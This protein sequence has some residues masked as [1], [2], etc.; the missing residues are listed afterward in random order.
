MKVIQVRNV[1]QA[2]PEGCYQIQRTGVRAESRNGPVIV[3]PFPLTTHYE[4][5]LERVL[6]WPERDANPFFHFFESLW[7]LAGNN[8]VAFVSQFSENIANYSDDGVVFNGAYGFRWRRHFQR[9]QLTNVVSALKADHTCRR[10]VIG[11]WDPRHDLGLQSKD[12][13]CNTHAYVQVREG[14]LDMMVCNRSND[15]IWGAYGANAVHFSFLL[16]YLAEAIGV[17]VGNYWQTSMNT[18]IYLNQHEALMNTM[19]GHAAQP[20]SGGAACP[21]SREQVSP[22][23]VLMQ[24]DYKWRRELDEFIK[25]GGAG[26]YDEAFFA[27]VAQPLMAAWAEWKA[28][29]T[30][31]QRAMNAYRHATT[32]GASDWALA[33]AEWLVR[34]IDKAKAKQS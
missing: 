32:C 31:E 26:S 15:M 18:H 4:R 16:Q 19:A 1:H 21:Y 24:R 33:C 23:T 30:V 8:D 10:Q 7:M 14:M 27:Q 12:V 34:R 17:P 5:P 3:A 6:F 9:D 25:R 2:L 22:L 13:P 11:M 20:Q 28:P 29:G